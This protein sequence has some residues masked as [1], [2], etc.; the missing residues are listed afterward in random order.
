MMLASTLLILSVSCWNTH[1][2]VIGG[3]VQC[4]AKAVYRPCWIDHKIDFTFSCLISDGDPQYGQRQRDTDRRRLFGVIADQT[5]RR[6]V[7]DHQSVRGCVN[8]FTQPPPLCLHNRNLCHQN[9][10]LVYEPGYPSGRGANQGQGYRSMGFDEPGGSMGRR[11]NLGPYGIKYGISM[12][13]RRVNNRKS[14]GIYLHRQH[15]NQFQ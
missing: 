10:D 7:S 11:A 8:R 5:A 14:P 1:A 6:V 4:K 13:Y 9:P 3:Q 15:I 12:G 2:Q